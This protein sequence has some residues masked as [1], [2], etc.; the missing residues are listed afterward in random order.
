MSRSIFIARNFATE[1]ENRI[2][3]DGVAKQ[4]GFRGGL[5]PGVA[6][7]GYLAEA[8]LRARG[9]GFL[10]NGCVSVRLGA[11][12]YDGETVTATVDDDG[13]L[14]LFNEHEELCVTGQAGPAAPDQRPWPGEAELPPRRPDADEVSL[15]V[16]TVL[17]SLSETATA[18]VVNGH[19]TAIDLDTAMED[20]V[21][22]AWLI[23]AANDIL[24][25]SVRLGPWIHV[26]S[27]MHLL[28][29]VRHDDVVETRAQV[30]NQWERK[31]HHFVELDVLQL[32]ASSPVT[33]TRH[34]AIYRLRPAG[35]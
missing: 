1:S 12:V 8:V 28:D 13:S 9:G 20:V 32:V 35:D 27:E 21:H 31:G 30:T 3:D 34:T 11:P 18:E 29:L 15:A 7:V 2:H 19:L 14:A 33:R 24:V 25:R 26:A 6:S 4:F 22:P 17:G 5:V 23:L 10:V 16:G